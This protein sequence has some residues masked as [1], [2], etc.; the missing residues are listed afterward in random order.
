[1]SKPGRA[2]QTPLQ[3]P[4]EARPAAVKR[5]Q[6]GRR[7]LQQAQALAMPKV[8]GLATLLADIDKALGCAEEGR[9]G[10]GLVVLDVEEAVHFGDPEQVADPLAEVH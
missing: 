10:C 4:F 9:N 7:L 3:A 2:R 1:M 5:F 8:A 6:T